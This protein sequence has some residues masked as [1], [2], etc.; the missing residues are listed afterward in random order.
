M[1]AQ[2]ETPPAGPVGE[3]RGTVINLNSGKAVNESLEVMLHVLDLDLAEKDMKHGQS[4]PDGTFVFPD[5]PF[6]ANIQFAVMATFNAVT[7]FSDT[8]PADM[9]SMQVSIDVPVYETTADLASISRSRKSETL[10][11]ENDICQ[12]EQF[13]NGMSDHAYQ[14]T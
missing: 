8:M 9:T 7:Y 2:A 13:F 5:V 3:V 10:V 6:D 14:T 1:L 11:T 12:V 4:Q